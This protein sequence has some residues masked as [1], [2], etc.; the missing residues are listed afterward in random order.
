[1]CKRRIH[2]A[3]VALSILCTIMIL[4][5]VIGSVV[6]ATTNNT[7]GLHT[8]TCPYA[9]TETKCLSCSCAWCDNSFCLPNHLASN[10][11]CVFASFL[12]CENIGMGVTFLFIGLAIIA[13]VVFVLAIIFSIVARRFFSKDDDLAYTRVI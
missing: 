4:G 2:P 7:S 5:F 1:M 3:I 6:V 9:K 10:S 8:N 12:S 13:V 11:T